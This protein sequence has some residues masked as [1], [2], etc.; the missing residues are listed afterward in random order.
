M[1][2]SPGAVAFELG[3]ISIH[4][5]GILIALAFVVAL[6]VSTKVARDKGENPENFID[7]ATI[8]LICALIG[9]RIY[10]VIFNFDYYAENPVEI[11]KIWHGGL[12]IHGGM[13]G[14]LIGGYIFTSMKKLSFLR[15]C[16]ITVIGLILGQAIGRWGNFFNSEAFGI[17][18][19]LPWKLF[20][21]LENRPYN[22]MDSEFFHPTFLY[23]SLWNL[24]VFLVLFFF[25]R[26]KFK[27]LDGAVFFSYIALYSLGRM[28]IEALRTDSLMFLGDF[29]AAQLASAFL[30]IIAVIGFEIINH[31]YRKKNDQQ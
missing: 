26:K 10:Y 8:V 24:G 25:I 12:A 18:T 11:I 1:F 9:A 15:Y 22:Y 13:L 31:R 16:D 7:L 3:A 2:R 28:F 19:N 21:P 5:Y 20:I 4:W 29:R 27:H 14:G 23:E 30:I 6:I 17:P